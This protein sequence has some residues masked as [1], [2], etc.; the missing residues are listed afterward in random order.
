MADPFPDNARYHDTVDA[1]AREYSVV[2]PHDT[3]NLSK[4]SKALYIGGAGN[5]VA[6]DIDG[7]TCEFTAVPAGTVLPIRVKRVNATSTTATSIVAL[8]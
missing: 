2:T 3:T 6:V 5:V 1:P 4:L 8:F 7:N